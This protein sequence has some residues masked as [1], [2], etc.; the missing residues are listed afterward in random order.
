MES[1][2]KEGAD[3]YVESALGESRIMPYLGRTEKTESVG[4]LNVEGWISLNKIKFD[5]VTKLRREKE[6][7]V[8]RSLLTSTQGLNQAKRRF[9]RERPLRGR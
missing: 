9:H 4:V 6:R 1:G 2:S 8:I 7:D 3:Q 5:L